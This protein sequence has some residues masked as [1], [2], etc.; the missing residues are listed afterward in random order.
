MLFGNSQELTTAYSKEKHAIVERANKEVMRHLRAI[1][2]DNRVLDTWSIDYLPLVMRIFNSEEKTRT[3]VSPAE[4]LFGNA[5]Q[6][7]KQL[8]FKP[9]EDQQVP[10]RTGNLSKHLD[11]LLTAQG[12]L[13]RVAQ[14]KQRKADTY[15]IRSADPGFTDYPVN[16]YV[17]YSHPAEGRGKMYPEKRGPY[18]VVNISL[19]KDEIL[20]D[21]I[22]T[23]QDFVNG[24]TFDTHISNLTPFNYNP[25]VVDPRDILDHDGD[26]SRRNT[27]EF[28]VRWMGFDATYDSWEPYENLRET[29]Q[30]HD[31]LRKKKMTSLIHKK[32]K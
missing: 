32:F 28:L 3:G 18:Q 17:L 26:K 23:I 30:L 12:T 19:N 8:L 13:I 11:K 9:S 14:E 27:M 20:R 6:L 15:H 5:V 4:L 25:H 16:S 29:S 10:T 21:D 24:K 2:F 31:Y 1:I 22:Y 7:H